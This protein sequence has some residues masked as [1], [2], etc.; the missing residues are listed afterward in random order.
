MGWGGGAHITPHI[1]FLYSS[2]LLQEK[3]V[4]SVVQRPENDRAEFASN[5][6]ILFVCMKNK[7]QDG[8]IV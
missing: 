6:E 3:V 2:L 4:L 8:F 1:P 7:D 5:D